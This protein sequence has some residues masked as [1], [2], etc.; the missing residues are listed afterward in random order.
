[1]GCCCAVACSGSKKE[2]GDTQDPGYHVGGAGSNPQ[3]A[4]DT[5]DGTVP[6]STSAAASIAG[7]TTRT[8]TPQGSGPP[9]LEFVI[10]ASG[11]MGE[12]PANPADPNGPKKWDVLKQT[13]PGV[14]A[15]L[16]ANFAAGVAYYTKP[17]SG[18]FAPNQAVPIALLDAA[19]Q[20][21]ITKSITDT[22][23]GGYTPTYSAWSAGAKTVAGWKAPTGYEA[24]PRYIVLITDGVPTV[25]QNGCDTQSPISQTEYDNQ[26]KAIAAE[27]TTLEQ[28]G[29]PVKTFVVGVVGSENPQDATYDPL[30]MLSRLAQT[31]GTAPA[32]CV[33]TSGTPAGDTVN[34]RG[35]YCHFDLSQASDFATALSQSIGSIAH[36]VVS[37]DYDVPPPPAGQQIDPN[38]IVL[39]LNDGAG[40]YSVILENTSPTCDKGWQFTDA[41]NSKIHICGA[42]CAMIQSNPKAEL[43]LVFGC[44]QGQIIN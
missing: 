7:C 16:P 8:D 40:N 15:S 41:T 43:T 27:M 37:C 42:T 18:C 3:N 33:P 22:S 9:I 17:R 19:Q 31:G 4:Q 5:V 13:M 44:T 38:E 26:L 6:I 25:Q 20:K 24:S 35:T 11:S 12:D 32:G 28:Q 23:P 34:P 21:L 10:D 2:E 30:Y 36:S 39:K 1:M 14:F 29:T